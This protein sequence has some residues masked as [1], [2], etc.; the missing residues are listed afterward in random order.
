MFMISL[1]Q[2]PH[3][4]LSICL[5]THFYLLLFFSLFFFFCFGQCC[6][7]IRYIWCILCTSDSISLFF[8]LAL[9]SVLAISRS[10]FLNALLKCCLQLWSL[11]CQSVPHLLSSCAC[12]PPYINLSLQPLGPLFRYLAC[13]FYAMLLCQAC[14]NYDDTGQI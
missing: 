11:R 13:I 5:L 1:L 2:D 7:K 9:S 10:A 12:I 3:G 4:V 6:I 8:V 14:K